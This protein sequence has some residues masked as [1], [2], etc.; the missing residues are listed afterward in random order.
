MLGHIAR[1]YGQLEKDKA[2][3]MLRSCLNDADISGRIDDA[4]SDIEM[5]TSD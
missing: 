3:S 1:L 4:L 2:V 5:V